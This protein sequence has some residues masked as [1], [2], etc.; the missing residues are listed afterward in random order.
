MSFGKR[1]KGRPSSTPLVHEDC[2]SGLYVPLSYAVEEVLDLL[3]IV[4]LRGDVLADPPGLADDGVQHHAHGF[5][6]ECRYLRSAFH[7]FGFSGRLS[8]AL[9]DVLILLPAFAE[10]RTFS[11]GNKSLLLTLR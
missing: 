9:N 2:D 5:P 6:R 4:V 3:V 11:V 7:H 1:L 8:I 10:W